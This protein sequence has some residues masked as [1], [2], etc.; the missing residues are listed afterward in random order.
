[1]DRKKKR[2]TKKVLLRVGAVLIVLLFLFMQFYSMRSNAVSTTTAFKSTV[3]DTVETQGVFI[4]DEEVIASPSGVVVGSVEDGGKV[5][6]GGEVAKV[7]SNEEQ[8]HN[9]SRI[10]QLRDELDYYNSLNAQTLGEAT[11]IQSMDKSIEESLNEFIRLKNSSSLSQYQEKKDEIN[12]LL[13]RRQLIT[14]TT[15]DFKPIIESINAEIASLQAAG[16]SPSSVVTTASSGCVSSS[17]DGYEGFFPYNQVN[18]LDVQSVETLVKDTAT[19]KQTA[20]SI[21]V[22]TSFRWY[23]ACVVDSNSVASL[24]VGDNISVG[25][26]SNTSLEMNVTVVKKAADSATAEKTALVLECNDMQKELL[27][28]RNEKIE[29]RLKEYTGYRVDSRALREVPFFQFTL[30]TVTAQSLNVED[31]VFV[32]FGGE[33][34]KDIQATITK[35]AVN[36]SDALKTDIL[37]K[38]DPNDKASIPAS[39]DNFKL[40]TDEKSSDYITAQNGFLR[41]EQGVYVLVSNKVVFRSVNP[42]YTGDGF[43]ISSEK[44]KEQLDKEAREQKE[45]EKQE[46]ERKKQE[47]L[48]KQQQA[49]QQNPNAQQNTQ[50]RSTQTQQDEQEEKEERVYLYSSD[51]IQLYDQ[52]I[53][54][55]KELYDDKFIN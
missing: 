11:D 41:N 4:R 7:F 37:V 50:T 16:A 43:F 3:Y 25:V 8:A 29:L 42:I 15:I 53:V 46:E 52:V 45:I 39:A 48:Q 24:K 38:I 12:D 10:Q 2:L 54:E 47:E 26:S 18:T 51:Y 32:N 9:Y 49:Q 34:S 33:K 20:S 5:S 44:S 23:I 1:M 55:G 28:L 19:K 30:D 31:V 21:K 17:V 13:T 36:S 22:I 14:G 35:K 6:N 27:S 40:K